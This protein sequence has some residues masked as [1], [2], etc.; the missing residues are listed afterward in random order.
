VAFSSF[1]AFSHDPF[2]RFDRF[3]QGLENHYLG[4]AEGHLRRGFS[5]FNLRAHLL[6]RRSKPVNLR[7]LLGDNRFQVLHLICSLRNSLSNIAFIATRRADDNT[8]ALMSDTW[9]DLD[10]KHD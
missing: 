9:F 1:A 2:G 5:R 4:I 8:I 10:A 6:K 7:V 3:V